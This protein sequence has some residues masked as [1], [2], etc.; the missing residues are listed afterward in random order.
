M[1]PNIETDKDKIFPFV[2]RNLKDGRIKDTYLLR[3]CFI[4]FPETNNRKIYHH[5]DIQKKLN[6]R[7]LN[8]IHLLMI[9]IMKKAKIKKV[10]QTYS[11]PLSHII[12]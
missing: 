4:Y 5:S 11:I 10:Y 2:R 6:V 7:P 8:K 1:I 9:T 3:H 12:Q